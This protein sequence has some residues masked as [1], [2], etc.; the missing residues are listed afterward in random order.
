MT[1]TMTIYHLIVFPFVTLTFCVIFLSFKPFIPCIHCR[2]RVYVVDPINDQNCRASFCCVRL[3]H[4]PTPHT[5][6]TLHPS[7]LHRPFGHVS[8]WLVEPVA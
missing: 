3:T 2:Y 1:M 7:T 6:A 8:C 4:K 5:C